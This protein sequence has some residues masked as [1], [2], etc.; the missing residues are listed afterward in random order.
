MRDTV[1]TYKFVLRG[2]CPHP[3][4][5][6]PAGEGEKEFF[7]VPL[8]RGRGARGEGF[9]HFYVTPVISLYC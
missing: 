1:N 8:S 5:P 3:P 2:T 4:A 6:S 7:L 9:S